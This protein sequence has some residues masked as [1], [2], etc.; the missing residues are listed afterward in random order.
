M[1]DQKGFFP[2]LFDF[3]F[4]SFLT[5]KFIKLIYIIA[6][7]LILLTA[8]IFFLA[9]LFSGE[10]A[11]ILVSLFVVPVLT[12]LYLVIA[13]ISLETVVV[14]FRIGENTSQLVKAAGLSPS[15]LSAGQEGSG[16]GPPAQHG[17]PSAPW[18]GGAHPVPGD[19]TQEIP[20]SGGQGGY[21][22]S[23]YGQGGYGQQ[24]PFGSDPGQQGSPPQR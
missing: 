6:M 17:P 8:A 21:G 22:Q 12:L 13:R 16:Y 23:G 7:V 14:F 24:G 15:E 3:S 2:T 19:Q 11:G 18:G 20:P 9:G 4:R 10:T 5:I 1:N